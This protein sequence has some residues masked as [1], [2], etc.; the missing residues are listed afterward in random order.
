MGPTIGFT[1]QQLMELAGFSVAQAIQRAYPLKTE[2]SGSL[3]GIVAGPGNNGG[4]GLVCA[5]HLKLF[6][7]EPVVLYPSGAGKKPFYDQLL[8]Q[9]EF[10]HVPVYQSS[11]PFWGELQDTSKILCIVDA[12]FGFSFKPPVRGSYASIIAK[13][14]ELQ[15]EKDVHLVSVDVPSGWDVDKGPCLEPSDVMPEPKKYYIRPNLLVS[16]TLPKPCS[17]YLP[18]GSKHF[19]GG[20]F[21]T[22]EFAQ[23]FNVE[24]FDYQ[25]TDQ[26]LQLS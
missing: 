10:F 24:C 7:Y 4:D 5:R 12:I 25:G 6:G 9:L 19:V 13:M 21:I 23:R 8:K 16:L 1:L 22:K 3:V 15:N 14:V 18:D 20:R 11:E 2:K 17:K 26:V